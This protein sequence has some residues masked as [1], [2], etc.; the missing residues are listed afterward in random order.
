MSRRECARLTRSVMLP[1][2]RWCRPIASQSRIPMID[3]RWRCRLRKNAAWRGG[4]FGS[5]SSGASDPRA[6]AQ[7][8]RSGEPPDLT[9]CDDAATADDHDVRGKEALIVRQRQSVLQHRLSG[10]KSMTNIRTV[11]RS[12]GSALRRNRALRR[13]PALCSGLSGNHAARRRREDSRRERRAP[14]AP[15]P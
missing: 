9:V 2:A 8:R 5:H 15:R 3:S 14:S 7:R 11:A 13:G 4:V 1:L 12:A 6:R 10:V